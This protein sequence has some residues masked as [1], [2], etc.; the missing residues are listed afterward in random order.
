M[1]GSQNVV[2]EEDCPVLKGS[3]LVAAL[4]SSARS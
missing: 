1:T 2:T 4:F 3:F